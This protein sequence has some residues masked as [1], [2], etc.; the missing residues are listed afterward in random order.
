M[1][2]SYRGLCLF[3]YHDNHLLT[4]AFILLHLEA[5]LV[6]LHLIQYRHDNH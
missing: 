4:S 3:S 1:H 5:H 2:V 6:F